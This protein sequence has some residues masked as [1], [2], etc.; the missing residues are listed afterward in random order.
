MDVGGS[1]P[2]GP[3]ISDVTKTLARAFRCGYG[4]RAREAEVRSSVDVAESLDLPRV[5]ESRI[6]GSVEISAFDQQGAGRGTFSIWYHAD[7]WFRSSGKSS[8]LVSPS[9]YYA[10]RN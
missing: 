1:S 4:E 2:S 8:E 3:T 10:R 5:S 7:L 6:G 9:S